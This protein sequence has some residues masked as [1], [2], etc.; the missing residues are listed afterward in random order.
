MTPQEIKAKV[1][2]ADFGTSLALAAKEMKVYAIAHD[3]DAFPVDD[4]F[5]D[6][7]SQIRD[8]FEKEMLF[9]F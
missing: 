1:M 5:E 7:I 4:W 6:C 2:P 3:L 9:P 8:G